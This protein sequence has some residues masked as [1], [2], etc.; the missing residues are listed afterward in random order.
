MRAE[1]RRRQPAMTVRFPDEKALQGLAAVLG[2]IAVQAGG[3]GKANE[4]GGIDI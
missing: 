4:G 3:T 1:E 2:R